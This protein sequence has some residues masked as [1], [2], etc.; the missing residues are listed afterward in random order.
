MIIHVPNPTTIRKV[1]TVGDRHQQHPWT[2]GSGTPG[3][4]LIPGIPGDRLLRL[5]ESETPRTF[6]NA[7]LPNLGNNNT[8]DNKLPWC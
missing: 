3:S 7:K 6:Q 2:S 4:P 8:L 1:A 5:A